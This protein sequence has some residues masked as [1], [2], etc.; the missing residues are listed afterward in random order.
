[1]K[2]C[3]PTWIRTQNL[4][5][6]CGNSTSELPSHQVISSA[7]FHLKPNPVTFLYSNK[8][9]IQLRFYTLTIFKWTFLH[10]RPANVLTTR[11]KFQHN[12][13]TQISYTTYQSSLS[14][15]IFLRFSLIM[16]ATAFLPSF[17]PL[18][19]LIPFNYLPFFFMPVF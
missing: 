17:C 2:K 4:C 7:T 19:P 6:P 11:S 5:T 9:T 18:P 8:K 10:R 13:Q 15:K 14:Q 1:M 12:Y 16:Q 3:G